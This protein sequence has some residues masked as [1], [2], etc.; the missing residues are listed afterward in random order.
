MKDLLVGLG[1]LIGIG[2]IALGIYGYINQEQYGLYNETPEE[3]VSNNNERRLLTCS[4]T[5]YSEEHEA[6]LS[7]NVNIEFD[8]FDN[9]T[10]IETRLTYHFTNEVAYNNWKGIFS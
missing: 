7:I 9:L 4:K 10:T 1:I 3:E 5:E 6:S 2:S 8:M